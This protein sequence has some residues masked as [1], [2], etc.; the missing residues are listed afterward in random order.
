MSKYIESTCGSCRR[1]YTENPGTVRVAYQTKLA[2]ISM[3][4][5]H[6]TTHSLLAVKGV[7]E[8][9]TNNLG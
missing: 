5:P 3:R 7:Y 9:T 4:Q 6:M 2:E 1:M 8:V